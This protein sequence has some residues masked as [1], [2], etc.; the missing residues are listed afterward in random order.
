MGAS[1]CDALSWETLLVQAPKG[2]DLAAITADSDFVSPLVGDLSQYL[3]EEWNARVSGTARRFAKLEDYVRRERPEVAFPEDVRRDWAVRCLEECGSF[4]ETRS[5]LRHLHRAY[6]GSIGLDEAIRVLRAAITNNQVRWILED[7]DIQSMLRGP[8]KPH[9]ESLE[10]DALDDFVAA[11]GWPLWER[12][13]QSR[14]WA[15]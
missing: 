1:I 8:L 7:D 3:A 6:L 5:T 11:A 13:P 12:P 2:T 4:R 9:R 10:S 15:A 14:C